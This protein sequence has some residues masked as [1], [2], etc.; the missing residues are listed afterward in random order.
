MYIAEIQDYRKK[1]QYYLFFC[2]L[3]VTEKEVWIYTCCLV[4]KPCVTLCHPVDAAHQ[5]P[6]SMGFPRQEYWSGLPFPSPGDLSNPG[7]EPGSPTL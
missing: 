2:A 4:A 5:S 7:I 3:K 1:N 6:L